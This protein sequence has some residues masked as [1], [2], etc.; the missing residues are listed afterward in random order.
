M[1]SLREFLR[2]WYGIFTTAAVAVSALWLVSTGKHT[3]FVHP[4]YTI[5]ITEMAVLAL[6]ACLWAL[7]NG[8]G[9]TAKNTTPEK[10]SSTAISPAS[11]TTAHTGTTHT[12]P[13]L[14]ALNSAATAILVS[15]ALVIVL[16]IPPAPL[17]AKLA[18][19]RAQSQVAPSN[20][21]KIV[22][23]LADL[24]A[25]PT[26][27]DW[28][29]L[30]VSQTKDDLTEQ[31]AHIDGFVT[32]DDDIAGQGYYL[33]R[34]S[35]ICCAVDAFPARVPIYDPNWRDH[36]EVGQWLDIEGA[37]QPSTINIHEEWM[38][39]PTRVT[40]IEEPENPYLF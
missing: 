31:K 8:A 38:L 23:T 17:S 9:T 14:A 15:T 29:K 36:V 32:T 11:A 7:W 16:L 39:H 20:G 13:R 6:I 2:Q 27:A 33:V 24:P 34:F 28:A 1:E 3:L 30:L 5:F 12:A 10:D 22:R 25:Q 21:T 35:I 4:R 26:T 40:P 19:A 37:F 18:G